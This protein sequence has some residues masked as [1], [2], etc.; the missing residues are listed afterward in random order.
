MK[1]HLDELELD[2]E[3]EPRLYPPLDPHLLEEPPL[4]HPELEDEL[5]AQSLLA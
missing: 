1:P 2:L 4:Y 5:D 3:E